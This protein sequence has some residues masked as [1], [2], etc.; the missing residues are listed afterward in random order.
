MTKIRDVTTAEMLVAMG[1]RHD[2]ETFRWFQTSSI[3]PDGVPV[4]GDTLRLT[5]GQLRSDLGFRR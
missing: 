5:F 3:G 1:E 2:D 4:A